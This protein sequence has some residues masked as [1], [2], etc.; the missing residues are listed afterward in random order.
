[1]KF[2][3]GFG[4]TL[5][6]FGTIGMMFTF[7]GFKRN[8][9]DE[10]I[11]QHNLDIKSDTLEVDIET[12]N[13]IGLNFYPSE[14]GESYVEFVYNGSEYKFD[15]INEFYNNDVFTI[16]S[17][18][19]ENV[20]LG[21][22]FNDLK[23]N[24]YLDEDIDNVILDNKNDYNIYSTSNFNNLE[25]DDINSDVD[26]NIYNSSVD[27]LSITSIFTMAVNLY[28]SEIKEIDNM[29]VLFSGVYN[30]LTFR[31][32]LSSSEVD[33]VNIN[34]SDF[35]FVGE[36]SVCSNIN[37]VGSGFSFDG[38][39]CTFDS[40]VSNCTTN[41]FIFNNSFVTSLEAEGSDYLNFQAYNC[42]FSEVNVNSDRGDIVLDN[43]KFDKNG[44]MSF[45]EVYAE[46]NSCGGC[47]VVIDN[48]VFL[49][50]EDKK[51]IIIEGFV[52][53]FTGADSY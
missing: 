40:I 36:N 38:D 46:V 5:C 22:D 37:A 49:E 51:G 16:K 34:F 4:I 50:N 2:F 25:L 7:S 21:F 3:V 11:V 10:K 42:N 41:D 53:S 28:N 29:N 45:N 23:I 6:I 24:F 32:Y 31:L 14:S 9:I 26:I 15:N 19:N 48:E 30:P 33:D 43:C 13:N 1:M 35:K 8:N 17:L 52:G 18:Q 39:T 44:N 27:S 12:S 20:Y 47:E